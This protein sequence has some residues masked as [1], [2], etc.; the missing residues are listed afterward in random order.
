[1]M[2]WQ[3]GQIVLTNGQWIEV[4]WIPRCSHHDTMNM[5]I[6]YRPSP[7]VKHIFPL[8]SG[9]LKWFYCA[10]D[11]PDLNPYIIQLSM[12]DPLTPIH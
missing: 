12:T 11:T 7:G 4:F 1:L 10:T 8:L 3:I 5:S 2:Y 6:P 9:Y